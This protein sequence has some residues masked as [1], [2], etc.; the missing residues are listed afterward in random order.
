MKLEFSDYDDDVAGATICAKSLKEEKFGLIHFAKTLCIGSNQSLDGPS[1]EFKF[2]SGH[3][4]ALK[5]N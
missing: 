5:D 1:S 4:S 3:K 2:F